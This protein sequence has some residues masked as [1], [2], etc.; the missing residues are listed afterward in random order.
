MVWWLAMCHLGSAG[1]HFP[2]FPFL[3]GSWLVLVIVNNEIW[4]VDLKEW[5]FYSLKVN[6]GHQTLWQLLNVGSDQLAHRLGVETPGPATPVEL[7][8][9]PSLVSLNLESSVYRSLW[10]RALAS[11]LSEP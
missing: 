1:L 10:Q 2:E 8:R 4:K 7:T 9:S 11:F 5:P 6:V 3:H